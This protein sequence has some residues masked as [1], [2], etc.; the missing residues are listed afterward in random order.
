MSLY[1]AKTISVQYSHFGLVGS[2][3]RWL[4][5]VGGNQGMSVLANIVILGWSAVVGGGS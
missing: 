3:Q 4:A 2:G 1:I 5:M